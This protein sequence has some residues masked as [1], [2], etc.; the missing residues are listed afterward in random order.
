MKHVNMRAGGSIQGE[1]NP[2]VR[3]TQSGHGTTVHH[4]GTVAVV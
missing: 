1:G 3:A 2:K 4:G